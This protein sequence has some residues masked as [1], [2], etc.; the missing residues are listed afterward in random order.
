MLLDALEQRRGGIAI[1]VGKA[2]DIEG[3]SFCA[4]GG[5][6]TRLRASVQVASVSSR[7]PGASQQRASS[8]CACASVK[9]P[10]II[11]R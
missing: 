4:G 5:P 7:A 8:C 3:V 9:V 6:S 2:G 10:P 11:W 1:G